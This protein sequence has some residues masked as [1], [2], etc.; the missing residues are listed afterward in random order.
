MAAKKKILIV[1]DNEDCR[2]LLALLVKRLGYEVVEAATGLAAVDQACGALPDLILMDLGLPGISGDEA[3][4][5]LKANPSTRDIPVV[6]NTAFQDGVLTDRAL[7]VGAAEILHKPVDLP[8]L[9]DVLCRYAPT[10][11]GRAGAVM[12]V[13]NQRL[14]HTPSL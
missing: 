7:A 4:A 14:Y 10:E 2:E 9:R 8:M 5:R 12:E 6:I 11:G 1:E 13:K 3:T